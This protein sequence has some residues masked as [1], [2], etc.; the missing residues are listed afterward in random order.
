MTLPETDGCFIK[1]VSKKQ[2]FHGFPA[3]G[4]FNITEIKSAMQRAANEK[5]VLVFYAH[6]ITD[7][8]VPSHHIA[9][10]Q[11]EEL[12]QYAASLDLAVKGLN[13]L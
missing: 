6:N 9:H 1:K 12:L 2:V 5:S 4:N 10:S 11:L 13:E 7:E 3:C 8:I